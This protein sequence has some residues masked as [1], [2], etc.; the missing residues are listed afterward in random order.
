MRDIRRSLEAMEIDEDMRVILMKSKYFS[1]FSMGTDLKYL[2]YN[3]VNGDH[4]KIDKYLESLYNFN[5]FISVYHKPL[6]GLC[7]GEASNILN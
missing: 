6:L 2:Y 7:T 1:A 3:K 4:H 5:Y